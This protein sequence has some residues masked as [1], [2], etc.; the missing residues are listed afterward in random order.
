MTISVA[1]VDLGA[2][3]GRVVRGRVGPDALEIETVA[4]FPNGPVE[5]DGRPALGPPGAARPRA[6]RA[7]GG[8]A[9]CRQH[10]R[11]LVG[12]RL[13]A[14]ARRRAAR[15]AVV[16]PRP[17]DRGRCR[18]RC[19]ARVGVRTSSTAAPACSS[20]PFNTIYQLAAEQPAGRGRPAAAGPRPG[21][22]LA[23]RTSRLRAHQ[24]LDDRAARRPHR[25]LGP[26]AARPGRPAARLSSASWSTRAPSSV[27]THGDTRRGGRV[28]RHRVRRG[29]RPDDRARRGV[30]LL[31]APGGWSASSSTGPVVTEASRRRELH[32]RG[33]R[34]RAGPVPH[35]RD[36]HLAAVGDAAHVGYRAT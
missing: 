14:A 7:A 25:R 34:R 8:R 31:R 15:A 28:P 23:D 1:A 36:G 30:H 19:T 10:R 29:R 33:R 26:G 13:R 5:R 6:G 9:R 11:R 35:Q 17:P 12:G 16:L 3:S 2:S 24:R 22:L 27:T 4:R 32:Q 21:D 18:A 20:C